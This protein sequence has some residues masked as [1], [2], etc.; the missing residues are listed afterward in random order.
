MLRGCAGTACPQGKGDS[1]GRARAAAGPASCPAARRLG[2]SAG[3]PL[4]ATRATAGSPDGTSPA[5]P[6]P[7]PSGSGR[8][9]AAGLRFLRG[10][11]ARTPGSREHPALSR[12]K[13]SRAAGSPDSG[14]AGTQGVYSTQPPCLFH[15]PAGHAA[16]ERFN[17]LQRRRFASCSYGS[18]A[19]EQPAEPGQP[20]SQAEGST[21]IAP[22][23]PRRSQPGHVTVPGAG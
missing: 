11:S 10:G 13:R 9:A 8:G 17:G 2:A 3:L 16:P 20:R 4:G 5:C 1:D 23:Q 22:A 12:G 14:G 7:P 6:V 18:V 21:E 15:I 19:R